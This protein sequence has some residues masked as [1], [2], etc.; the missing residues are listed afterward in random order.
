MFKRKT[1]GRKRESWAAA[2]V[3]SR[4][5]LPNISAP[6]EGPGPPGSPPQTAP[7]GGRG[8]PPGAGW[9]R[10]PQDPSP[11]RSSH[12]PPAPLTTHSPA[13]VPRSPGN[14]CR[15]LRAP[16]RHPLQGVLPGRG[17]GEA[18]GTR[19]GEWLGPGIHVNP[20]TYLG[21]RALRRA[22]RAGHG[23]TAS[24]HPP[25]LLLPAEP[26]PRLSSRNPPRGGRSWP[27]ARCHAQVAAGGPGGPR[28]R[29]ARPRAPGRA[30]APPPPRAPTL[31][32]SSRPVWMHS[33]RDTCSRSASG[34][35]R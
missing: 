9:G 25:R 10:D 1:A 21:R 20:T 18:G 6:G 23:G 2:R 26:P 29:R 24:E 15:L 7:C 35:S 30:P 13:Q 27:R 17:A 5:G 28:R 31:Q 33:A 34:S 3:P 12:L 22:L 8:S 4:C 11:A 32:R 16:R 19:A 14:S